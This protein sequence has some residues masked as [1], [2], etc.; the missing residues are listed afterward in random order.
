M[1][2]GDLDV[3]EADACVEHDG[4]EGVARRVWVHAGHPDPGVGGE[5]VEPAGC[6]VPVH[7]RAEGVA[8]DRAVE[9]AVDCPVY[10]S[11]IAGGS[12]GGSLSVRVS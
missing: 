4:D 12:Y 10:G 5:V 1:A 6:G 2:G 9:A 3:A 7:P 11:G 8:Q